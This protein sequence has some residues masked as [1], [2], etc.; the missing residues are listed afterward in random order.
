MGERQ[1]GQVRAVRASG[2]GEIKVNCGRGQKME[3]GEGGVVMGS[4]AAPGKSGLH[5]RGEGECVIALESW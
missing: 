3:D 2:P 4:R 5:A 1:W